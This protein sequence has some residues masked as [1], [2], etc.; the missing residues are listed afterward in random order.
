MHQNYCHE[1]IICLSI[2]LHHYNFS[3]TFSLF[4]VFISV[5]VISCFCFCFLIKRAVTDET[6]LLFRHFTQHSSFSQTPGLYWT[7][8]SKHLID[9]YSRQTYA[10]ILSVPFKSYRTFEINLLAWFT[11]TGCHKMNDSPLASWLSETR[12]ADISPF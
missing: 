7:S 8:Y 2:P 12:D 3:F 10:F 4:F 6:T 5:L 9:S 11:L 1:V